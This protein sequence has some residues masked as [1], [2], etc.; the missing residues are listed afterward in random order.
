MHKSF[1]LISVFCLFRCGKNEQL[2]QNANQMELARI[3]CLLFW[4]FVLVLIMCEFGQMV[5]EQ[6]ECFND[7]IEQCDWYLFAH[8][9]I[10]R[11]FSI[12]VSNTQ[13]STFLQSFGNIRCSRDSFKRVFHRIVHSCLSFQMHGN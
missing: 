6:F 1:K 3:S 12:V 11:M 7:A 5:T 8:H 13:Q 10:Q 4:S 2:S 9:D